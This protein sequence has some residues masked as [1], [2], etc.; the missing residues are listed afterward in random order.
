LCEGTAGRE[1]LAHNHIN[2]WRCKMREAVLL[3]AIKLEHAERIR[4]AERDRMYREALQSQSRAS[5][6]KGLLLWLVR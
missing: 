2:L 3:E 1:T 5:G 4:K 6:L